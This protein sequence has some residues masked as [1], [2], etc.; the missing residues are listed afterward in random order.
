MRSVSICWRTPVLVI[1]CVCLIAGTVP[2]QSAHSDG[3]PIDPTNQGV[4]NSTL[5]PAPTSSVSGGID[6]LYLMDLVLITI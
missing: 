5:T 2:Y 1:A 4:P 6:W 3:I